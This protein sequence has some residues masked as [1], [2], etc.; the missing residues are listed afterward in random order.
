LGLKN[1]HISRPWKS[2]INKKWLL[3]ILFFIDQS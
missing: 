3:L 2:T 1:A